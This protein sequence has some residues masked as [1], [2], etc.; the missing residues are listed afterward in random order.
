MLIRAS[1][2]VV[3]LAFALPAV[4]SQEAEP[5]TEEE[6]VRMSVRGE[7]AEAIIAEIRRRPARFALDDEM[8]VE[9]G[10]AG[11]PQSVIDAMLERMAELAPAKEPVPAVELTALPEQA[12]PSLRILLNPDRKAG[13]PSLLRISGE[14]DFQ[15]RR[16]LDL[17]GLVEGTEFSDVAIFLACR[18]P[19][20]VPDH[21]RSQS[22]LG[23]DFDRMP[24]HRLLLLLGGAERK[25]RKSEPDLL[26]L[27]IP[28]ELDVILDAGIPHHLMLGIAVEIGDRYY[29]MAE[30]PW[31]GF[32]LN[33]SRE[34]RATITSGKQTT[35]FGQMEV[36]FDRSGDPPD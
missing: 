1:I 23:R 26:E 33:G 11:V 6:V 12:P 10:A 2:A 27:E 29:L 34:V 5:L 7:T 8:I 32:V 13:K 35:Q 18:S 36:R 28:P 30:D 20:H 16:N 22:A 31:D 25:Q 4:A 14:V 15:M 17:D 24:R 21:W 9:L 19:T 3:L